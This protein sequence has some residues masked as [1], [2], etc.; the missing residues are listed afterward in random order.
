MNVENRKP[1]VQNPSPLAYLMLFVAATVVPA[2]LI[3]LVVPSKELLEPAFT[4]LVRHGILLILGL[5]AY[6][7][8][9]GLR[10]YQGY[11]FGV[12]RWMAGVVIGVSV[13]AA[14]AVTLRADAPGLSLADQAYWLAGPVAIL[15]GVLFYCATLIHEAVTWQESDEGATFRDQRLLDRLVAE[16]SELQDR[17]DAVERECRTVRRRLAD[18]N[19]VSSRS[20]HTQEAERGFAGRDL[21]GQPFPAA[22][23]GAPVS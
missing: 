10:V 11:P 2:T 12:G 4:M 13:I 5:V 3:L 23:T 6:L 21:D 17:K 9:I 22:S 19:S 14:I 18:V 15:L 16:R 20:D 8:A 7:M 1:A